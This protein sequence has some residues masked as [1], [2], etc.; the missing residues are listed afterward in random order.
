MSRY[1]LCSLLLG[2]VVGVG[3]SGCWP[4][5]ALATPEVHVMVMD[6]ETLRPVRGATVTV[7][8]E[9]DP[10][11]RGVGRT[12]ERGMAHVPALDRPLWA[13]G[14]PVSNPYPVARISV[15]AA[16]YRSLSFRSDE[17]GGAAIAG[18]KPVALVP[19]PIQ[20]P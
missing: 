17:A 9:S 5:D 3:L 2:A 4:Y 7:T 8:A 11:V 20:S 15:E 14:L 6:A 16:G 19:A 13:P 18:A 10:E 1:L 12:D